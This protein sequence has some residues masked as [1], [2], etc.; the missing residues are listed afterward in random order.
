MIS[1]KKILPV[2][3]CVAFIIVA[4]TCSKKT[5]RIALSE[6][7]SYAK[8]SML[9][10]KNKLLRF[11]DESKYFLSD[12][13]ASKNAPK[14]QYWIGEAHT[15]RKEYEEA[16]YAYQRVIDK[17]SDSEYLDDAYYKIGEAYFIQKL[18]PQRDQTA[19]KKAI[20]YYEKVTQL[21]SPFTEDARAKIRHCRSLLAQ[22]QYY[23]A[24]FYFRS[25][26]YDTSLA[27]MDEAISNFSDT[28]EMPYFY[29]LKAMNYFKQ[30]DTE[31]ARAMLAMM[32][33]FKPLDEKL[34]KYVQK[35]EKK[36]LKK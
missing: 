21:G 14:V 3:L 17:Y 11:L 33:Q 28:A 9:F 35:L 23:I 2:L 13:P 34:V 31:K 19:T 16:I 1:M 7:D 6:Q 36:M 24:R 10:E 5:V 30:K 29:Y 18:N 32:E 27:L 20:Y 26:Q 12:Y 25:K 15:K 8:V 22:K 4:A